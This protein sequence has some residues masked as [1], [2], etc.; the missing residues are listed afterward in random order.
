M[1]TLA[2]PKRLWKV[3]LA[4]DNLKKIQGKITRKKKQ[5]EFPSV[6]FSDN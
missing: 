4:Y 6:V 5:L 3:N 1:S 2:Q